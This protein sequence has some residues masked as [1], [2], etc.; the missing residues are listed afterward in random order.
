MLTHPLF[1]NQVRPLATLHRQEGKSVAFLTVDQ[2]YDEFN[3][4][5]RSPYAIKNFLRTATAA[6]R[7]K[8]R[9]LLLAGDASVDPRDYLGFGFF[10]FVPT[11]IVVTSELKTASDDWFSDFDNSGFARIAT[12]RLPARTQSDAEIMVSKTI[13][14]ATS[15]SATWTNQAMLVADVDEDSVSFSQQA[16]AIQKMLPKAMNVTDVFSGVLGPDTARQELIGG[17]DNGQLLVNYN[18]H[19]SVEV[20][21]GSDL[22]DNTTALSLTNGNR[23]PVFVMMNCLNGFFHDVYTQSLATAL[24]ISP[25]RGR[26]RGLGLFRSHRSR[27][28]IPDGSNFRSHLIRTAFDHPG[29]CGVARKIGNQRRGRPQD[30]HPVRRSTFAPEANPGRV[31]ETLRAELWFFAL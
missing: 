31:R 28:S 23:L 20:W 18:G 1:V 7:T 10:D 5:E 15:E 26:G 21:S 8:P 4:G 19:G 27:S 24:M 17:I 29:R 30:I 16:Q 12:G 22:F 2:I 14:Y 13:G 3:F 25:E 11:K 6:W 9:Y